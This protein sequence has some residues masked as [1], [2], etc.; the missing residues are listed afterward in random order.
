MTAPLHNHNEND[1]SHWSAERAAAYAKEQRV[2]ELDALYERMSTHLGRMFIQG[3]ITRISALAPLQY[4][5]ELDTAQ[6]QADAD[7]LEAEVAEWRESR[8]VGYGPGG[9][10]M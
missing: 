2:K 4:A 8:D 9:R 10:P 7:A 1:T 6:A 5:A 3:E